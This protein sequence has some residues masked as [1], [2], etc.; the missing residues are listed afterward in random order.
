M[1]DFSTWERN[2]ADPKLRHISPRGV[3]W[4]YSGQKYIIITLTAVNRRS[5]DTQTAQRAFPAYYLPADVPAVDTNDKKKRL[6]R[7]R[8]NVI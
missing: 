3:D 6:S 2:E 7:R 4:C 8:L 5:A 1:T